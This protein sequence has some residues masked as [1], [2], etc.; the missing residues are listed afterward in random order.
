MEHYVFQASGVCYA[1]FIQ[2]GVLWR[3]GIYC[4]EIWAVCSMGW[5]WENRSWSIINWTRS[6]LWAVTNLEMRF[7]AQIQIFQVYTCIKESAGIIPDPII[8]P[9]LSD[10]LVDAAILPFFCS[11]IYPGW[12]W[13]ASLPPSGVQYQSAVW[14][15]LWYGCRMEV[16]VILCCPS[17]ICWP[18]VPKVVPWS[19]EL[20]CW[21]VM[22]LLTSSLGGLLCSGAAHILT[23]R[24]V[25][26]RGCSRRFAVFRGVWNCRCSLFGWCFFAI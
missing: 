3:H 1:E 4:G 23:V 17:I 10:M 21:A 6:G 2:A 5:Q 24:F 25:V 12:V 8:A 9:F 18:Y 16:S 15:L 22:G 13:A 7:M 19:L 11:R 26:L 20:T 14:G